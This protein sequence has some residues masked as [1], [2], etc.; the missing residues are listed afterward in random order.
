EFTVRDHISNIMKRLNAQN[1]TEV[2]VKAIRMG[3]IQ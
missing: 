2:A 1:R 3:I